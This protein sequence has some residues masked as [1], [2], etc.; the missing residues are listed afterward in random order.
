METLRPARVVQRDVSPGF[1]ENP[2]GLGVFGGRE[3]PEM[4]RPSRTCYRGS[5]LHPKLHYDV[6]S[7][8]SN[9]DEPDDPAARFHKDRGPEPTTYPLPLSRWGPGPAFRCERTRTPST[10]RSS[11]E[12]SQRTL[13]G[14]ALAVLKGQEQL[15]EPPPDD[16]THGIFVLGG[17][18]AGKTA[19]V[20][21]LIAIATGSYPTRVEAPEQVEPESSSL[22]Q[23]YAIPDAMVRLGAGE[24]RMMKMLLSDT[25][26]CGPSTLARAELP[27]CTAANPNDADHWR[28]LAPWLRQGL[29]ETPHFAACL[30][31]DATARPLWEDRM[32]CRES[33]KLV[34]ALMRSQYTVTIAV[35]KLPAA[36]DAALRDQNHGVAHGGEPHRDPRASYECF[37][38]RYLNKLCASIYKV[39]E[40]HKWAFQRGVDRRPFPQVNES[41]FDVPTWR[42]NGEFARTQNHRGLHEVPNS[43]YRQTQ[44]RRL[45]AA[46]AARRV[47]PEADG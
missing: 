41:I 9:Y 26:A 11:R 38:D 34:C 2:A 13:S 44:L 35:T 39:L 12:C 46:L 40:E 23:S 10:A 30:V 21:S 42:N 8:H 33:V 36:R 6:L 45:L 24:A 16:E 15:L 5:A 14:V 1:F 17:K 43:Y 27:M 37:V 4:F 19:L 22:G 47:E 18:G 32:R 31:V 7:R 3:R 20:R 29:T 28:A 25:P